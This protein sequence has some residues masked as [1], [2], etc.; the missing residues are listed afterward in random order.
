MI[1]IARGKAAAAGIRNVE[2]RA[3]NVGGLDLSDANFDM[4]MA[5]SILHL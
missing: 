3:A 5:H 2:F 1:E 4:V